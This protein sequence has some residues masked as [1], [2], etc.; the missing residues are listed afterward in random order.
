MEQKLLEK[1]VKEKYAEAQLH[2]SNCKKQLEA[3]KV[4][5]GKPES[6]IMADV[7]LYVSASRRRK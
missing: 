1:R 2:L 4:E 7:E 5:R 3:L 6:S